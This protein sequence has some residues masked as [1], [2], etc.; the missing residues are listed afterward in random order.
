MNSMLQPIALLR[1]SL[2][3]FERV[4]EQSF[5][6]RQLFLTMVGLQL[7]WL[8]TIVWTGTS[9]DWRTITYLIAYTVLAGVLTILLPTRFISKLRDYKGWLLQKEG[10]L[11]FA[12]CL[13]TL[14]VGIFYAHHQMEWGDE[15]RSFRVANILAAESLE[16]AY[17]E[18]GWLRN[19]HPPL[20]P[21]IYGLIVNLFGAKLLYLRAISVLFLTGTLLITYLI[22]R[23][24]YDQK[25][26]YLASFLFLTFP[27]VVRLGSSAMMDMQLAFF[28]TLTLLLLLYLLRKPSYRL[29]AV[30]GIVIGLGLLTKYIMVLVYGVLISY[31]VFLPDFRKRKPHLMLAMMISLSILAI[32]LLHAYSLGILSGQIQKIATY[33]GIYHIINDLV[34]RDQVGFQVE[35]LMPNA[36]NDLNLVKNGIIR[37]GLESLFTRIPSSLG[38]Y[39]F[40]LILFGL[41]T[42]LK[43]QKPADVFIMLWIG[44]V[45]LMLFLTLPDHRYFLSAFP[46]IAILVARS[47]SQHPEGLER[48]ILLCL[49]FAGGNL[50]LF[51]DWVREAHMFL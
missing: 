35:T 26:G 23:E 7:L 2:R 18:S 48:A 32:W 40:P 11:L 34:V 27:L 6:N 37:L 14:A 9:T 29:S 44:A 38:V 25:T 39:H 45:F 41:I 4:H 19:K 51:A 50:Y 3:Q 42:L 46:A 36:A 5:Q 22:G 30:I 12:L 33:S 17:T 16:Y 8:A 31:I 24:L 20:V 28:F 13:I 49:F 15:A 21:L 43:T 47:L 10:Y 1:Y